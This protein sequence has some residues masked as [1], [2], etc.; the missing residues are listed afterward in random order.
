GVLHRAYREHGK[1]HSGN[2]VREFARRRPVAHPS[3]CHR[4]TVGADPRSSPGTNRIIPHGAAVRGAGMLG[5]MRRPLDV[6]LLATI[7]CSSRASTPSP[8]SGAPEER[9]S[10]SSPA[11]KPIVQT[12]APVLR[13][14]AR[15]VSPE[16]IR[17]PEMR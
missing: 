1:I 17:T 2:F 10:A 4:R 11:T 5:R 14:R 16:E 15:E 13:A 9:A 7:A 3:A 6:L 8:I 12:G